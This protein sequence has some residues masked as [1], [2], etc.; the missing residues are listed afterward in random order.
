MNT[1][2]PN[3]RSLKAIEASLAKSLKANDASERECGRWLNEAKEQL[4]YGE[5]LSWLDTHFPHSVSTAER[6]MAVATLCARF[7]KLTNLQMNKGALYE[8]ANR[9][10]DLD[11]GIISA[12]VKAAAGSP[13]KWIRASDII[14]IL[15]S[16]HEAREIEQEA[17][18]RGI[19]VAEL[20][21]ERERQEEQQEQ[22]R[23]RA[24][25]ERQ[26][27]LEEQHRKQAEAAAEAAAILDAAF[28]G[29]DAPPKPIEAS[30]GER[31]SQDRFV[32]D[33]LTN[34]VE[35]LDTIV[36]KSLQVL[37][38]ASVSSDA[39][40][41]VG[42]CLL[43]IVNIRNCRDAACK[44]IDK[45]EAEAFTDTDIADETIDRATLVEEKQSVAQEHTPATTVP[46]AAQQP[47]ELDEGIPGFLRRP[48]AEPIAEAGD[49]TQ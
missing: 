42:K 47:A 46:A 18:E 8:L 24:L 26:R 48:R 36:S 10:D 3:R 20:E 16:E 34:A 30:V 32:H 5:W 22:E 44:L 12:I 14:E 38:A 41:R 23:Q 25:Q 21:Q 43:D 2:R 27:A 49:G 39:L 6:W 35:R 13:D 40:E 31:P 11:D 1:D 28:D 17:K 37:A 45:I 4:E 15:T 33:T 29:D 19:T 9:I 7:V